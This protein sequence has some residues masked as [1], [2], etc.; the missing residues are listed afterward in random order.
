MRHCNLRL[1]VVYQ[2][3]GYSLVENFVKDMF[4]SQ[5]KQLDA[6]AAFL[7][8]NDLDKH[9]KSKDW[10]AFAKGYN[11]PEYAANKYDVKMKDAYERYAKK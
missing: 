2:A 4:Q 5:A 6:F 9:L 8:S 11:G 10:A 1:G 7:K 3:C